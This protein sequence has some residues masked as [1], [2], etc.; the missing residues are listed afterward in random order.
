MLNP[1]IDSHAPRLIRI[2]VH[3][4]TPAKTTATFTAHLL[5]LP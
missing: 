2:V 1:K 3:I 4:P 5:P